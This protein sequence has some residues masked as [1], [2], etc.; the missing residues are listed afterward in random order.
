MAAFP[1]AGM[2]E[3][4]NPTSPG[5]LPHNGGIG[6]VI[7]QIR[8]CVPRLPYAGEGSLSTV[9]PPIRDSSA[10]SSFSAA[11][12][13]RSQ[14]GSDLPGRSERA[15]RELLTCAGSLACGTLVVERASYAPS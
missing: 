11:G 10:T 4:S 15:E 6:G 13:D 2:A 12:D 5:I 1:K 9:S 8:R 14:A 3:A 7:R